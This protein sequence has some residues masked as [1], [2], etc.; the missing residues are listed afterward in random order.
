MADNT[1]NETGF[2]EAQIRTIAQIVTIVLAQDRAQNQVPPSS[3]NQ[4]V[5]EERQNPEPVSENQASVGNTT[6]VEN[7]VLK[8]LAD[9]KE[10]FDKMAAMKEKDPATNFHITEYVLHPSSSA[11]FKTFKHTIFE[12]D[13]DPR[14]HLSEFLR[15]SQMNRYNEEDVLHAFP[16]TLHK[17]YRRWYD[18]LDEEVQKNWIKLQTAFLKHFKTDESDEFGLRDLEGAGGSNQNQSGNINAIVGAVNERGR[19]E[20]T[21]LGRPL[22]TVLRSCIKNGVLSKLPVDPTKPVRG[23]GKI[24]KPSDK[25]KPST[26]N[27][28]LPQYQYNYT[29]RKTQSGGSVNAIGSGLPEEVVLAEAK[30]E[31]RMCTMLNICDDCSSDEEEKVPV[32]IE[33]EKSITVKVGD[34]EPLP[35]IS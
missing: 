32:K 17:D 28:P 11:S 21:D 6:P 7:D 19:R 33:I 1:E 4:P 2:S 9:L 26:K 8:Q 30:W 35:R 25:N 12:G 13:N 31:E 34:C 23:S 5:V 24:T 3:S 20:F 16:Q 18:G 27:N 29:Y 22:S 14:S 10:R 15:V